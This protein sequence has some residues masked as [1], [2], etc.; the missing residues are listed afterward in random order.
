MNAFDALKFLGELRENNQREWFAAHKAAYEEARAVFEHSVQKLL[1]GLSELDSELTGLEAKDC[2]FRIYR[3]VRLSHDKSPYKTHF[4][5]YLAR[6]GRKSARAGYYVH[7][8]EGKSMLVGGLWCPEPEP[9]KIVRQ[10]VFDNE[11][12]LIDIFENKSFSAHFQDFDRDDMLKRM[13]TAFLNVSCKRPEWLKLKSFVVVEGKEDAFFQQNDWEQ[14]ALQ[15]LSAA[16]PLNHF[17]NYSLDEA[18]GLV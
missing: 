8:E 9:L 4:G 1:K 10:S 3:D 16:Y 5:A 12:E 11:D 2:V 6:G 17:L 7:W 18:A 13:P 14:Q 15:T